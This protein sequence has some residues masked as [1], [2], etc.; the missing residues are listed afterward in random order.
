MKV[1]RVPAILLA[2]AVV[3]AGGAGPAQGAKPRPAALRLVA[4]TPTGSAPGDATIQ[5]RF[6]KPLAPITKQTE[7]RLSPSTA[8]AWSQPNPTTLRF[9]P[10]GAYLPGTVVKLV[11]PKRLA[12]ADGSKLRRAVTAT[13]QVQDGS[14]VRL[15]QLLAELRFLPV[16]LA[17]ST[18]QPRPG[19]TA[20]QLRAIFQPP[21]GRLEL[22]SD[23]PSQ[24]R[25]VWEHDP[26]IVLRAR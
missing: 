13:Y 19:D 15:A 11:V 14:T 5:L 25:E 18:H 10:T 16:H 7:P 20:G 24:L 21:A 26:S 22:G 4:M 9:T 6:S 12:A 17:S 1:R 3:I 2:A 23:W 8:G